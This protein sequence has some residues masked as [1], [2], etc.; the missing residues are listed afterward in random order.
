M[1]NNIRF[2][3]AV[4]ILAI[5]VSLALLTARL[6]QLQ[7]A[8][9]DELLSI[10]DRQHFSVINVEP[11]RGTIFDR[12]MKE[13]ALSVPVS[14]VYANPMAIENPNQASSL[15]SST[16]GLPR[17]EL[18]EK[19]SRKRSFVW[20]K[21]KITPAELDEV[22]KLDL[23]GVGFMKEYKRFYPHKGLA[24]SLIGFVGVDDQGLGG[25]EYYFDETLRREGKKVVA[26]RDARGRP[27]A[28]DE[29]LFPLEQPGYDLV[30]AIDLIVQFIAEKALREQVEKTGAKGGI[31]IVMDPSNGDLLAVAEKPDFNANNYTAYDP[32]AW[33]DKVAADV[34]EPG[35]TFKFVVASAAIEEKRAR[36]DDMFFAENGSYEV[37]GINIRD[38]KSHGWL[39]MRQI[40]EKSSNIGAIKIA[41]LL[42]EELFYKYIK[43]F[44]F[45]SKTGI[46]LPGES[47]GLLRDVKAWNRASIGA[48]PIGQE[49]A[50]TPIQLIAAFSAIANGGYLVRPRVAL[51]VKEGGKIVKEYP[52]EIVRRVLSERTSRELT[53]MLVNA[54]ENGTGRLAGVEGFAVAGKT[55]TAQK[56]DPR[57]GKYS[58]ESF[59]S[60]FIGYVPADRPKIAILVA[61][62]EP[63]GDYYGGVVA[64]PVFS[65]VARKVMRHLSLYPE[66][67]KVIMAEQRATD[68]KSQV[69]TQANGNGN[70]GFIYSII[71]LYSKLT[72][73]LASF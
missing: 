26:E 25:I 10:A 3:I 68:E 55:G 50:V 44:G 34:F 17:G 2:R 70:K 12:K 9:H 69:T 15:L 64:A 28:Y 66:K 22:R 47:S 31:L 21:R 57:S 73:C 49:I 67:T 19:L 35:S 37:G 4:I 13:L 39:T 59:V 38:I 23:A 20:I 40:V 54:V 36:P 51:A 6:Y 52:V 72:A 14:S 65:Q 61:I 43:L 24:G 63:K 16:L 29:D 33:R 48:L 5:L 27:Y 11:R 7:V 32:N 46:E 60:S 45:G 71:A 8:R 62:D 18:A 30:L 56:V 53:E 41:Q 42:G 1:E 58:R